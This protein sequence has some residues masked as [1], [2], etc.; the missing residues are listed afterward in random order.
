MMKLTYNT[1]TSKNNMSIFKVCDWPANVNCKNS[2]PKT[3]VTDSIDYDAIPTE[4]FR[5]DN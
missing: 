1:K 2:A 4:F 3:D 5:I